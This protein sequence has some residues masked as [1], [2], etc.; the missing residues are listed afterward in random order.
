[1]R[2][3]DDYL[4]KREQQIM[5]I[6]WKQGPS[7]ATAVE[8]GLPDS[9]SNSTVRTL[10]KLLESKG[11]ITRRMEDGRAIYSSS[12]TIDEEG[13]SAISQV[14]DT[15]FAGSIRSAVAAMVDDR[16]RITNEEFA[17]IKAIIEQA[18][19]GRK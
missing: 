14:L 3:R 16:T 7:P 6:L 17:E 9:P 18:E 5:E 13:K 8:Q 2:N 11:W 15:F 12:R 19:R 1:M 10:L 4:S